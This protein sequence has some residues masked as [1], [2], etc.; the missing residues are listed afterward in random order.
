VTLSAAAANGA[1]TLSVNSFTANANYATG[2][3]GTQVN[4]TVIATGYAKNYV[5]DPRLVYLSPPYYLNPGTSEWG[6]AS[7][8]VSAGSCQLATGSPNT[9][10]CTGYP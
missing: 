5:Y 1:T 6:F 7:F 8:T 10:A 2:N 4:G 9:A 3:P